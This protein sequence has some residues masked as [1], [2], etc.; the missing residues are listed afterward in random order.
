VTCDSSASIFT[1]IARKKLLVAGA[2]EHRIGSTHPSQ[3]D[4]DKHCDG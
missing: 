3:T 4:S 1:R 2:V